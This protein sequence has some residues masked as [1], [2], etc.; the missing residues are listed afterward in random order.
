MFDLQ[1]LKCK[2]ISHTVPWIR[3]KLEVLSMSPFISVVYEVIQD[4]ESNHLQELA[5]LRV[6]KVIYEYI[7]LTLINS[8]MH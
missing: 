2:Y 7:N 4:T 6:S 8:Y 1:K 3:Y 5:R